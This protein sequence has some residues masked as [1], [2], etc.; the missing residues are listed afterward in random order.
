MSFLDYGCGAIN[1]GRFFIN[2]LNT[3]NYVGVD[4]S[5]EAINLGKNRLI[6][7]NLSHKKPSLIHLITLDNISLLNKKFDIVWSQSVSTH[8]PPADLLLFLQK[9]K[10]FLNQNFKIYF[11]FGFDKNGPVQKNLKDWFY[12]NDFLENAKFCEYINMTSDSIFMRALTYYNIQNT[13]DMEELINYNKNAMTI[14][15]PDTGANPG[16][17]NPMVI[18][19]AGCQMIAMRYEYVDTYLEENTAFF[20]KAGYAFVLKPSRL[21]YTPVTNPTPTPQVKENSYQTRNYSSDY[22]N[23]NI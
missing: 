11:T 4:I 17:P 1:S 14:S 6:D 9:I 3:G 12:N 5:K 8:M 18:R 23:F 7:F 19:E 2:Y 20:D 22:Y 15:F 21:R 10:I 16:N 13:P